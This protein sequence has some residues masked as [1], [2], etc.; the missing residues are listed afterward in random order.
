[1]A[2]NTRDKNHQELHSTIEE[3][4]H[5][6]MEPKNKRPE[7]VKGFLLEPRKDQQGHHLVITTCT[8]IR[9]TYLMGSKKPM[10]SLEQIIGH[11]KTKI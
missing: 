2:L 1:M 7:E 5:D 3:G 10:K 6:S 9:L 4:K 8:Q 11:K